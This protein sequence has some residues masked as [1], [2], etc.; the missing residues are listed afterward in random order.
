[1]TIHHSEKLA[2][3][4][5][6]YLPLAAPAD[7]WQLRINVVTD[8]LPDQ[9]G[10]SRAYGNAAQAIN[11]LG[12]RKRALDRAL[13]SIGIYGSM[14][15]VMM[16]VTTGG[17]KIFQADDGLLCQNVTTEDLRKALALDSVGSVDYLP[18]VENF[19]IIERLQP[20]IQ[21]VR[22]HLVLVKK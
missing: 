6:K 4:L 2:D 12:P 7:T 5:A 18:T 10:L 16:D 11:D 21:R 1:M 13:R 17:T 8:D 19:K 9:I 15:P 22:P 20:Q 14:D 3:T